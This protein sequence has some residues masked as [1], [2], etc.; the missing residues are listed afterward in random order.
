MSR[1]QRPTDADGF[2]LP[3]KFGDLPNPVERD[4]DLKKGKRVLSAS[5]FRWKRRLLWLFLIVAA[6]A[7]IIGRFG[8]DLL[9]YYAEARANLGGRAWNDNDPASARGHFD[10]ALEILPERRD[11]RLL[12]AEVLAQLGLLDESH[13][14]YTAA[15]EE[16]RL[17]PWSLQGRANV[18]FRMGSHKYADALE[19]A[20]ALVRVSPQLDPQ[21]LNFRAYMR[22]LTNQEL[23]GGLEDIQTALEQ[24]DPKPPEYLDTRGYLYFRLGKH[25]RALDDLNLAIKKYESY[26]ERPE[27]R[28]R[29]GPQI[30]TEKIREGLA[31]M[32]HHRAEVYQAQGNLADAAPDFARAAEFGYDPENGVF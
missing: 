12:R 14:D 10:A 17:A 8:D 16:N 25:A 32:Y 20:D 28:R 27:R 4:G 2:P 6:G 24:T 11:W 9:R 18:L 23:P 3:S 21:A 13:A 22:A 19:D 1:F 7:V 30:K 26:L 29:F 5:G 31:V 15:L